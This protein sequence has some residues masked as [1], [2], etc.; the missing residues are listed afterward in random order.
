MKAVAKEVIEELKAE[1]FTSKDFKIGKTTL[2]KADESGSK[3]VL[4]YLK[5][6]MQADIIAQAVITVNKSVVIKVITNIINLPLSY[7][8]PLSKIVNE[9]DEYD[10]KVYAVIEAEDI[11]RSHLRIDEIGSVK[12]L[13]DDED[14][15]NDNL[16]EW[17]IK[18]FD[19]LDNKENKA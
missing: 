8:A 4:D 7:V 15:V 19:Q 14:T 2:K 16:H 9:N 11:N 3:P 5:E 12:E 13:T 1:K 18:Q 17:L 10:L 6:A